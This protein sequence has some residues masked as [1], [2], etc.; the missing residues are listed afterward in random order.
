[1]LVIGVVLIATGG[2]IILI[3][4]L[5]RGE[6]G[7]WRYDVFQKWAGFWLKALPIPFFGFLVSVAVWLARYGGMR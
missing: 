2:F 7:T 5:F 1:M 3:A 6:D 4:D